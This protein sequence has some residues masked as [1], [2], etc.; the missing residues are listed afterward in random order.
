M[1]DTL[2]EPNPTETME[3][4]NSDPLAATIKAINAAAEQVKEKK[5]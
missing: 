3:L 5:L 1:S 2:R 4:Y